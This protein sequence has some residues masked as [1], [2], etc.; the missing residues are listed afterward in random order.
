M[1]RPPKQHEPLPATFNQVL[2]VVAKSVYKDKKTIVK[3][4]K[5]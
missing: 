4:K 2:G 1:S 3:K 5:K